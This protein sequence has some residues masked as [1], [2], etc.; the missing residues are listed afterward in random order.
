M[1]NATEIAHR[2]REARV[3]SAAAAVT[4]AI[5][6]QPEE[7]LIKEEDTVNE[8]DGQELKKEERVK[9]SQERFDFIRDCIRGS[10]YE[11]DFFLGT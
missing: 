2:Q 3:R 6:N 5:A 1:L 11:D 4:A 9:T 8:L 10:N 7:V